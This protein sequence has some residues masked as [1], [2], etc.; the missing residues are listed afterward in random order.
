M[1]YDSKSLARAIQAMILE[2]P[3]K[4]LDEICEE[5][6]GE[7]KSKWTLY[8]ELNPEDATAKIGALDLVALM[9]VCG[10]VAPLRI[11]AGRLGQALFPLPQG[12]DKCPELEQDL[13][14]V[15]KEFSETVLAFTEMLADGCVEQSEFDTFSR[16][17]DELFSVATLWRERVR[18]MIKVR[19]TRRIK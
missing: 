13:S 3:G 12:C 2:H 4:S 8:K 1:A 19:T 9:R 15:T 16:E 10:D 11:M 5:A 6:F 7:G 18:A 17:L 14:K